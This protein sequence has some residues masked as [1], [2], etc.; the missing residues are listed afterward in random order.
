M[1]TEELYNRYGRERICSRQI[2]ELTGLAR[3]LCAD[4]E[5]NQA[6]VEFLQ[7]WLAANAGITANPVIC[8]LYGRVAEVL[9][10]GVVDT[11]E[12]QELLQTLQEFSGEEVELGETLKSTSL[13]LCDPAPT[14][15]FPERTYCFTGTFSYGRRPK[16]EQAVAERGGTCGSLTQKTH[17]LVV[18]VYATESWKHSAFGHKIMKASEMRDAGIPISIVSEGHWVRH[19]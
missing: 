9:A 3:G 8:Q 1:R 6:E 17:V 7:T 19:L 15:T 18:G 4:G 2:D 5:L 14:L 11:S 16:C 13:P 10:D 12:R